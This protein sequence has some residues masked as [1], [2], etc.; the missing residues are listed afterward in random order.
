VGVEGFPLTALEDGVGSSVLDQPP[1]R[2]RRPA[3]SRVQWWLAAVAAVLAWI[4]V[5]TPLGRM[6]DYD[7]A[8][9]LSQSGGLD[10]THAPH[11]YLVASREYGTPALT[12]VVRWFVTDLA[13]AELLWALVMVAGIV[14]GYVLASRF[15]GTRAA[16]IGFLIF[17]TLWVPA[18]LFPSFYGAMPGCAAALIATSLYLR[19]R[20]APSDRLIVAFLFGLAAAVTCWMRMLESFDVVLVIVAHALVWRPRVVLARWRGAIV[21]LGTFVVTFAVPWTWLT[22]HRWGSLHDWWRSARSQG[23]VVGRHG[24]PFA[25]H[26]GAGVYWRMFLGKGGHFDVIG[27]TPTIVSVLTGVALVLL[28]ALVVVAVG[29]GVRQGFPLSPDRAIADRHGVVLLYAAQFA[30]GLGMFLFYAG[31]IRERYMLYGLVFGCLLAGVGIDVLVQH[32]RRLRMPTLNGTGRLA[33]AAVA[34]IVVAGGWLAPQ[35]WLTRAIDHS[36]AYHAGQ[37]AHVATIERTV[38]HDKPCVSL[39]RA[40]TPLVQIV[41]GCLSRGGWRLPEQLESAYGQS[42][43]AAGYWT[44]VVWSPRFD[45]V[46]PSGPKWTRIDHIWPDHPAWVLSYRPPD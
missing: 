10:G 14:T 42:Y 38:A 22:I 36:R 46:H 21:A 12:A 2:W 18:I 39:G 44:F 11:W 4:V 41:S 33:A 17:S 9:F 35:L 20:T 25:L 24:H 6:P 1:A 15:V 8:V 3:F 23:S 34:V 13:S 27:G 31:D 30:V 40:A 5:S 16:V 28:L 7:E 43:W 37:A 26:N 29:W 32:R 45:I 19:W